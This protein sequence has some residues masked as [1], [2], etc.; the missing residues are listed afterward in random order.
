MK[1]FDENVLEDIFGVWIW[2]TYNMFASLKLIVCLLI[3]LD[4]GKGVLYPSIHQVSDGI[5]HAHTKPTV[6][7]CQPDLF[8]DIVQNSL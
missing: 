6:T 3:S 7:W 1:L 8:R 5:K 2:M 4:I